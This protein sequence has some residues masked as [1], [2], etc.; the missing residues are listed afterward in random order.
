MAIRS[1]FRMP[2]AFHG[3]GIHAS[4]F[5][6]PDASSPSSPSSSGY[7]QPRQ[8]PSDDYG[9]TKRKRFRDNGARQGLE[10]LSPTVNPSDTYVMAGQIGTSSGDGSDILGESMFSDSDYRRMLGTKRPRDEMD[11]DHMI[12][13]PQSLSQQQTPA[14]GWGS[15][16]AAALGGVVGRIWQFCRAGSFNGFHAG[17]GRG[18]DLRPSVEE[19]A[20]I[21]QD[22][23]LGHQGAVPG[24]FP[25][26]SEWSGRF[27]E[28]ATTHSRSPTPTGPA[29]KRRQ[30]AAT[31]DLG[32]NWVMVKDPDGR[33]SPKSEMPS[34]VST[35]RNR[36]QGPA[37]T[38][39]RRINTP[40]SRR[41]VGGRLSMASTPTPAIERPVSSASFA[42]QRSPSPVKNINPPPVTLTTPKTHSA[43][44]HRPH[45][46]SPASPLHR[47]S[48]SGAS[49]AS[50]RV[51]QDDGNLDS[52]PR[53][54]DEAR[55]LAARRRREDANAD[56]RMNA[57]S[58]TIQDMI[59][60]GQEALATTVEV[61]G[62]GGWEND[63][64]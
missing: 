32:K 3:E 11:P 44:R 19:D 30:T 15:Y 10:P 45:A 58:K 51:P 12:F 7:L 55:K 5:R 54:D 49:T 25:D 40:A 41:S 48:G 63:D 46:S 1:E 14:Q 4:I 60:Q 27:S 37:V 8:A 36:N 16:A 23:S 62:D 2:G 47:R 56:V 38:T 9:S 57:F 42:S 50:S 22:D 6:C 26:P 28:L 34:R 31:D 39:G 61:E 43:R 21:M 29:T 17:G 24:R 35:P 20:S 33:R 64:D 59:R 52:S 18:Y 13:G 53:L